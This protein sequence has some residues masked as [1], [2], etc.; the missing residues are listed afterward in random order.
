MLQRQKLLLK[1]NLPRARSQLLWVKLQIFKNLIFFLDYIKIPNISRNY[2]SNWSTNGLLEKAANHIKSWI[3]A[4]K[5]HG[6]KIEYIQDP[7][8]TPLLFVEVKGAKE[9]SPTIFLYG[10]FDKQPHLSGWDEGLGPTIP[11]I[12]D[13]KLYGRGGA[14]DGYSSF[15]A[16]LSIKACQAQ[17]LDHPRCVIFLEGDE[18][19][20][21]Q[22]LPHYLISLKEKIGIPSL[23]LNFEK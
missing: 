14:D 18:E 6:L 19:S 7:Q 16:I 4:Q 17:K 9:N 10:H 12:K 23:I 20:G 8:R 5:L 21:S 15:A 1:K 3:E 2:D 11:V 13:G 22:D